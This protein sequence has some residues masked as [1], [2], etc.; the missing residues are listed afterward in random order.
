MP[1]CLRASSD[2]LVNLFLH[3]V[4]LLFRSVK[5]LLQF[6]NISLELTNLLFV[7]SCVLDA[8]ALLL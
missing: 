1:V 2:V 4:N 8:L 3:C 7:G 5:L 6:R